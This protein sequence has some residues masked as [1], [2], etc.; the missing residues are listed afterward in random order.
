MKASSKG[1]LTQISQFWNMLDDLA[2]NDPE[3]YKNFIEQELKDGKQLYVDPEPQL[4]LQT[5]ILKPKEK[6]LFINLCQWKRIAAPQSATHPVPVS[7]GRPE[8]FSEASGSYTVID[9]AY[10]PCVL[11]ATEK[12]QRIKDQLIKMA[13]HCI[14]ERFQFTLA[15]SYHVTSFKIKGSIQ[16][17]KENLMGIKTGFTGFKEI[18]RTEDT[19]DNIRSHTESESDHLPHM[20][21]TKVHESSG[22]G[23]RLIE[24]VSSS[25]IRAEVKEP[26]YELKVVKDQNEKPLRVEVKIELPGINSASLCELSVSE[27]DL[28]I[29]V[30][31]KYRLYLKLPESV[32]TEITTAKF[33]KNKSVL[34][35]TMPLA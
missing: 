15:H 22:K 25:D 23:R 19:L 2:E 11:Q 21:L 34:F 6:I 33:V 20:L 7:V 12:D 35:I 31:E 17:M 4:C 13:M 30:S 29:E 14:E 27:V 9:V 1:L 3:R 32:N 18:M 16:R 5:K 10:N 26:A 28:L 8:D 24:E